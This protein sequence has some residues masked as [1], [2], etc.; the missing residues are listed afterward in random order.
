[1]H[2]KELATYLNT[3]QT[4]LFTGT[5]DRAK[6]TIAAISI[7]YCNN[8]LLAGFN[9][10]CDLVTFSGWLY[11]LGLCVQQTVLLYITALASKCPFYNDGVIV[12]ANNGI[13]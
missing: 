12:I 4:L 5:K 11:G 3:D 8:L 1:M 10:C 6:N 13:T 7:R 2:S 9:R